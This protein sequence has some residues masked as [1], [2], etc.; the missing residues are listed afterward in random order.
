MS[1]PESLAFA[2]QH[3][4]A[5]LREHDRDRYYAALFADPDSRPHLF[6]L[7]AFNSEIARIRDI[8]HDPLPGEV[9]LQW[10]RDVLEGDARG[11]VGGNPLA[12]ALT[13]TI[14]GR[15][16]PRQAFVNLIEART[17]DLYDDPMPDW[18]AF[19]G[20]CGETSSALVRLAALTLAGGEDPGAAAEAGH[21]GVAIAL[22]GLLR[23]L[24]WH[25]A[26]GR[27]MLP[28]ALLD[29]HGVSR[30]DILAGRDSAGLRAALAACRAR[31][32]GHLAAVRAGEGR[33]S[34]EILP[35]FLPCAVVEGYLG[36]ME[37]ADYVPF[38]TAVER[39]DWLKLAIMWRAT[40]QGL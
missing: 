32:R 30:A 25:A 1:Q 9:R 37:R 23:A 4:A 36:R 22:T 29:A 28:T 34:A 2:Y 24:P 26:R 21:A 35:A 18:D 40:R 11:G 3:A 13:E 19:E 20:Y 38:R 5:Q 8:V 6:A 39:A 31:A 33:I 16:L 17:F 10:W 27:V 14:A 15:H 12:V 7:Y